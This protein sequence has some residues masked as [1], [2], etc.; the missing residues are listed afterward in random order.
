MSDNFPVNARAN[1][2]GVGISHDKIDPATYVQA[3][4][5]LIIGQQL[6]TGTL[7]A[8]VPTVVNSLSEAEQLS[9]RGSELAIMA[10][11]AIQ[12]APSLPIVV[13]AITDPSGGVPATGTITVTGAATAAGTLRFEVNGTRLSVAIASGAVAASVATA[14][15]TAINAK[16][17]LPVTA[18]ASAGV[19]TL[20]VKWPGITGNDIQ[21]SVSDD[22][23]STVPAGLTVATVNTSSGTGIASVAAAIGNI[24]DSDDYTVVVHPYT[25]AAALTALE[26]FAAERWNPNLTKPVV[27]VGANS[28]ASPPSRNS[29]HSVV[30]G[31][32]N[33]PA[34]NG[35]VAA[36]VGAIV[37]AQWG[38]DPAMQMNGIQ[39]KG[40]AIPD[41]DEQWDWTTR[42]RNLLNG[43]STLKVQSGRFVVEQMRNTLQTLSGGGEAAESDRYLNSVLVNAAIAFD[44]DN[45]FSNNWNDAKLGADGDIQPLGQKIMTPNGFKSIIIGR[46]IDRYLSANGWVE[47]PKG[48]Q[49]S[50]VVTRDSG[51]PN[52][53]NASY[54]LYI[55]GN[56]RVLSLVQSF[57]FAN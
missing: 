13:A 5:L 30:V 22:A 50:L 53:L 1:L 54:Q 23:G 11:K 44:L 42:N 39:V 38:T 16:P 25:E 46:Y 37:A 34:T 18:A 47:N 27:I 17:D 31:T 41:R 24:V 56:L 55:I 20:T 35:E 10:S 48:F 28:A 51:N 15:A 29:F 21:I 40:I 49:D 12:N 8:D 9:G 32:Q 26:E 7:E 33:A 43:I 14:I 2:F 36:A 3:Q 45:Y 52:R 57:D 19:V 6:S 4:E